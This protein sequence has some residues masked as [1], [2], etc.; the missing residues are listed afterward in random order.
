MLLVLGLFFLAGA[1]ALVLQTV[2]AP[3][4]QRRDSLVRARAYGDAAMSTPA[5]GRDAPGP[6]DEVRER[7]AA[8]ALRLTPK[9]TIESI[10]V[11]L[12]EAGLGRRANVSSYL[13]LKALLGAGGVVLGALAGVASEQP[14]KALLLVV[15]CTAGCFFLPDLYLGMRIRARRERIREQLPAVLDMIAVS[16]EAGLTFDA[17]LAKLSEHMDGPLVEEFQLTLAE[18]RIGQSRHQALR[19]LA[20]RTRVPE[21]VLFVQAVLQA[22]Q[23]GSPLAR[24]LRVQAE[25][26][27]NRRQAAAEE[28]AAKLPVKMIFPTALF[29]FPAMFV[30]ILGPALLEITTLF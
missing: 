12:I 22:D 23:L 1:V 17:A 7:L 25:D 21:L 10:D 20:D 24:T 16:V 13:A 26:A 28:R 29:I 30:V 8:V 18:I 4:R 2:W 3:A 14:A 15:L 6:R 27:R 19:A 9:A 11:K 5:A